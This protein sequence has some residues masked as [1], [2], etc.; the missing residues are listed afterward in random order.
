MGSFFIRIYDKLI[1]ER[2]VVSLLVTLAIIG[3]FVFKIPEFKLDA[4]A[5]SLVLENDFALRYHRQITERYGTNDVLV[6]TYS[7]KQDL[8]SKNSLADLKSFRN[9][10]KTL[11]GVASLVTIL[12]VPLLFS[13]D[14]SLG[15]LLD[16]EKIKTLEDPGL[17][18]DAVKLELRDSPLYRNR[19]L[20]QDGQTTAI[21][22]NL[23]PDAKYRNLLKTRYKLR[24][25]KYD[26]QISP[27]EENQLQ[28]VSEEF[29][30]HLT[31]VTKKQNELVGAIRQVMGK[32]RPNAQVFLG[33]VPMIVTDMTAFIRNDLIV[34]GIGVFFFLLITLAIIFR[35]PRWV[36]LPM[37]C[38]LAAGLTMIGYL[39]YADWRVTVISSNFISLMLIFTM[40][41][42]IHLIVHYR[43]LHAQMPD[44]DQRT[45]VRETVRLKVIPC[46]YTSLTTIVAFISLL[47]SDIRP[48]M[49][50]GLM[51]TIGLIVSFILSFVLFPATAVLLAKGSEETQNTKKKSR[52]PFTL[53]FAR[54][55]EAHGG[56]IL[57]ASIILTIV[58]GIGISK[59]KVENRFIDYFRERTEI[60]Q[61]MK[62][63][64]QKLGGTT[65]LDLIIDFK[66]VTAKQESDEID[67]FDELG[68]KDDETA[69]FASSFRM[70]QIEKVH[71][72]LEDF[73]EIGEVLSIATAMKIAR[74]LNDNTS[75]ENYEISLLHKKSPENIRKLLIDPYV[76]E[77]IPQARITMR[78]TETDKNLQRKELLENIR[79][80]VKKELGLSDDQIHFTNMFVLYNN[81]LQSLYRS[82]ILTI[83]MVFL[84]IVL[85]FMVLFRSLLVALIA[86][87][88]N[89]L[90]AAMVLGTMGLFGIPLDMM[91]ITI[92]AI[93][94]GIAVDDTIHYIHR[95]KAEFPVDRNYLATVY[96]CHGSIGK[97]MY[98]TSLTIIIGFSI[99]IMSNFI[100]TIY[101]GIFTGF[102]MVVALLAALTL[103]P[104]LIILL[105]PF[106]PE[107]V[108]T[109]NP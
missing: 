102:A 34:F 12:D 76:S 106:G 17:D 6:L 23:L 35:K 8:F 81:M 100:P 38:C 19:L 13:S 98:Y 86:I 79:G 103:L 97:A 1:L 91:T 99:L 69:W 45:L 49:D 25:K 22:I 107:Q 104:Q 18:M 11:D 61:G 37:L 44:A 82:Q 88:P 56:K 47:V 77:D 109:E 74:R 87:V 28:E 26:S 57:I 65:P 42:T 50:F 71:D 89:L 21:L 48:V 2:P 20:S 85:M 29:R 5:D 83:G 80:F 55:T 41:L 90:P 59:L 101:F 70:E 7:P 43:E 14:V 31:V 75:L 36:I 53:F 93:T 78:A 9:E 15:D 108:K 67:P 30:R 51:M 95:F 39:G 84:G 32:Y 24:E 64:D 58:S 3:F 16:T 66:A 46:L 73:P 94:I 33:G 72:Y 60:Y 68:D 52:P 62:L 92:A 63:I 96:R 27:D 105:K 4:S 10:L 54:I 40:S